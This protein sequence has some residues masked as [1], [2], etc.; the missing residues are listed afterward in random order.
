MWGWPHAC[1]PDAHPRPAQ[2]II[3]N[4]GICAEAAYPYTARDGS[5]KKTCTKVVTITGF[6]DVPQDSETALLTAIVQQPVS[7][8]V[9][10]DQDSFQ[11]YAGG[12]MTAACG[13]NLD[14]G[15][16][17]VG[18]GTQGGQDFYQVK[19]SWGADWGFNG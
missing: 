11:H 3:D 4:K 1:P 15:V 19:N 12:V 6:K 7:V 5:C 13:T 14:H 8:A 10:A 18:Y 2:Y 9:E 16:L 17:A